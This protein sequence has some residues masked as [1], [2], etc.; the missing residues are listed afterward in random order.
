M[1]HLR[2][3]PTKG[4]QGIPRNFLI[5]YNYRSVKDNIKLGPYGGKLLFCEHIYR[6]RIKVYNS[7][8]SSCMLTLYKWKKHIN[9]NKNNCHNRDEIELPG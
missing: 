5:T 9:W 2:A 4:F 6:R 7:S 3:P 1:H 8:L